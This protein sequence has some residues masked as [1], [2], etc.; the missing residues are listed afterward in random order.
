MNKKSMNDEQKEFNI[1]TSQTEKE[2]GD[3]FQ[4]HLLEQYKL[5]VEMMDRTSARRGQSNSFYISILS[6][7]ISLISVLSSNKAIFGIRSQSIVFIVLAFLGLLLSFVWYENIE[8]YRQ[9]SFLK[10]KVIYEMESFLPM[11]CY[12]REWEVDEERSKKYRRLTRIEKNIPIIMGLLYLGLFIYL[13]LD[14]IK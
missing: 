4:E 11:Q 10:F 13:I 8:S 3:Q 6:V 2:Y 9:L 14:L 7:L 12:K 1:C 5:Y